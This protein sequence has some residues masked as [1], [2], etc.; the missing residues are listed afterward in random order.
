MGRVAYKTQCR[1][2]RD[3]DTVSEIRWVEA[4]PQAPTLPY[5]SAIMSRRMEQRPWPEDGVGEVFGAPWTKTLQKAPDGL[6]GSH[7]CGEPID[8]QEGGAYLPD[9][10][11][12]EYDAQGYLACCEVPAP[13]PPA[14]PIELGTQCF[15][16]PPMVVGQWYEAFYL[17]GFGIYGWATVPGIPPGQAHRVEWSVVEG[18]PVI[19]QAYQ[20]INCLANYFLFSMPTEGCYTLPPTNFGNY[21]VTFRWD[22][23]TTR[24][25]KV[26]VRVSVGPCQ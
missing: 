4:L 8:F 25:I 16:G 11:P 21:N 23:G 15:A 7:L 12:A 9:I 18:G 22:T 3:H 26:L 6:D 5:V 1:F 13:P 17:N 14:I 10:P 19:G 2:L 20:M 24:L